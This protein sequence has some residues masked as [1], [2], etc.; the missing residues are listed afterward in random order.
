[1]DRSTLRQFRKSL[2]IGPAETALR[3]AETVDE[4]DQFWDDY[5]DGFAD[6]TPEREHLRRLYDERKYHIE[7]AFRL[8]EMMRV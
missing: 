6:E 7:Q 1:M 5:C 3:R 8:A 2:T 4:L